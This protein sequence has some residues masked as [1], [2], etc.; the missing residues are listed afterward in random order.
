MANN[1]YYTTFSQD[2]LSLL[3]NSVNLAD[4]ISNDLKIQL[5]KSGKNYW[6][7]CPFHDDKTPSFIINNNK[8]HCFS[9][10]IS[11]NAITWLRQWRKLSFHDAVLELSN[12]SRIPVPITNSVNTAVDF[13]SNSLINILNDINSF[14]VY[15]LKKDSKIL[16][17][18]L[19]DRGLSLETI[20]NYNLGLVTLGICSLLQNKHS[21]DLLLKTGLFVTDSNNKL[22]DLLRYRITIPIFNEKNHIVSFAGRCLPDASIYS[23]YI[24]GQENSF[25]VKRDI[26][27]GLNFSKKYIKEANTVL[28]VEGYFDHM[29]LSQNNVKNSVAT[30][31]TSINTSQLNKIFTLADNIIF[32]F[33]G[34]CAG[35][36]AAL[37][38]AYMCLGILSDEKNISFILLPNNHDPDSFVRNLGIDHWNA[39]LEKRISLSTLI[40]DD[41]VKTNHHI[42]TSVESNVNLAVNASN[43]INSINSNSIFYKKAF[44][45][46]I[47]EKIGF[48]L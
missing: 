6:L 36:K 32:C 14:Y 3:I 25:F 11:G 27:F 5:K 8:Y 26:L 48:K 21:D 1:Q 41:L 16:N 28:I 45:V 35:V 17:F 9:C 42:S 15:K 33:D 22:K 24:N 39:E 47:E 46:G 34:D 7:S 12:I 4:L 20:N 44:K 19:N 40:I 2:F 30:L 13:D 37:K 23:K 18:L 10:S 31:G 29:I 38:V 43:I